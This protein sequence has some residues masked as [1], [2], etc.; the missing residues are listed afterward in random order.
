MRRPTRAPRPPLPRRARHALGLLALGPLVLLLAGCAEGGARAHDT[1]V[2]GPRQRGASWAITGDVAYE[3]LGVLCVRADGTAE[4]DARLAGL[5]VVVPGPG[6][7]ERVLPFGHDPDWGPD[8]AWFACEIAGQIYRVD[9]AGTGGV[10]RLT[11]GGRNFQPRVSPD[12]RFLVYGCERTPPAL[13][14]PGL[15]RMAVDGRE[16]N[17]LGEP[18]G[19]ARREADWFPDGRRLVCAEQGPE[20]G[21]PWNLVIVSP[22]GETLARLTHSP[23]TQG[24]P[25]V[26][27]EGTRIAY[28]ERPARGPG[29]LWLLDLAGGA[30]RRLGEEPAAELDWSPDGREILYLR[31][32]ET[33]G[34]D[35]RN[36]TL[37][38]ITLATGRVRPLTTNWP[39]SCPAAAPPTAPPD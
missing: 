9:H 22:T 15:R 6:V 17:D 23:R 3:D 4:A 5:R 7:N 24:H 32:D 14:G 11:D 8:G 35:A 2:Y 29:E 1:P 21:A 39:E 10:T 31:L 16:R 25:H 37:R 28:I 19:P 20:P 36:G 13:P 18:D 34:A 12:G 27:P 33:G 26:S 38:I 30:P